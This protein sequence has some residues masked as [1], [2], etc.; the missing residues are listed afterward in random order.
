[1]CERRKEPYKGKFNMVGGKRK[2][3]ETPMQSAYRELLEETGIS[4]NEITLTHVM[5]L[6]YHL[7]ECLVEVF[8]GQLNDD[9]EVYGEE[10]ELFWLDL[11][12][13]NF[14]DSEVFAGEG[15][16]GHILEIIWLYRE[17]LGIKY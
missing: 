2:V 9:F 3:G 10:N 12:E 4:Q 15:N 1:M 7:E 5:D 11:Q 8:F 14:F 16:I 13:H 17:K 6:D